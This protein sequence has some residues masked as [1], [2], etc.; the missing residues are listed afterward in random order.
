LV[1]W[2]HREPSDW[3][4]EDDATWITDRDLVASPWPGMA[5]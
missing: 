1:Q 3:R 2:L 4:R 5:M